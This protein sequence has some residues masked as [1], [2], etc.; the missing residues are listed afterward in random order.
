MYGFV[1]YKMTHPPRKRTLPTF[2]FKLC[3]GH[4]AC[5]N[6]FLVHGAF[7]IIIYITSSI[8]TNIP[9]ISPHLIIPCHPLLLTDF[10]YMVPLTVHLSH[11]LS[12]FFHFHLSLLIQEL[13]KRNLLQFCLFTKRNHSKLR[14]KTQERFIYISPENESVLKL[15]R[16]QK[17]WII[18]VGVFWLKTTHKYEALWT[19]VAA[20]ST[21]LYDGAVS[22]SYLLDGLFRE[23]HLQDV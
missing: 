23:H 17:K 12:F 10:L 16:S 9:I 13:P 11:I 3:N 18:K 15:L 6:I 8:N 5:T 2:V 19:K 7:S 1:L 14:S 22:I 4:M 20:R 21:Y